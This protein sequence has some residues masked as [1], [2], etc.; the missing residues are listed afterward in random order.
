M[1]LTR[2]PRPSAPRLRVFPSERGARADSA[3]APFSQGYVWLALGAVLFAILGFGGVYSYIWAPVDCVLFAATA[4]LFWQAAARR[5][6]LWHA[7]LAPMLGFWGLVAGQWIFH[8]SV[9]PAVTFTG[10]IQLTGC[11][12]VF[13]LLIAGLH[14]EV[15]WNRAA[16]LLWLFCGLLAAEALVQYFGG[17][18]YIYG[19]HNATYAWPVGPFVYHNHFAGCMDLLMPIA[20]CVA[21]RAEAAFE[22]LWQRWL[23]R[24]MVPALGLASVLISRSRGGLFTL[25]FE[26]LLAMGLFWPELRKQKLARA[27]LGSSIVIMGIFSF[28][29]RWGPMLRRLGHLS[30]HD[31]SWTQRWRVMVACWHIFGA[32]P[33]YG[34]GFNTFASVYPAFQLFDNGR[35]FLFAHNDYAQLLAEMGSLGALCAAGFL[36]LWTRAFWQCLRRRGR[37]LRTGQLSAFIAMAGFLLH[38]AGDFQFHN[39]ANALL[40]FAIGAMAVAPRIDRPSISHS[41]PKESK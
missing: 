40:F 35:V 3:V 32:H 29:A 38:A 33:L 24:G 30:G 14:T 27:A 25:S 31:P 10:L 16:W 23:R 34:T 2:S 26:L 15:I 1:S 11:G 22:P 18:G 36:W 20:L 28:A 41:I 12:C 37:R 19:F 8:I 9:Y 13:L 21:F 7:W 4:L 5:Q 17:N 39:P 6:W